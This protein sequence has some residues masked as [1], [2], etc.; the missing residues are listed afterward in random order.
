MI[1]L[2]DSFESITWDTN[3]YWLQVSLDI[4]GGS[5]YTL[6]GAS[7]LL[8]VPYALNAKTDND[9]TVSGTNM[10]SNVTGNIGIGVSIP[11]TSKLD[12]EQQQDFVGQNVH[13][14]EFVLAEVL[15]GNQKNKQTFHRPEFVLAEVLN[16]NKKWA[17]MFIGQSWS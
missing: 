16:G 15:N 6:M 5:S 13:R 3:S 12:I 7:Q 1:P 14:P 8:S 4:A 2:S 10:T 9:W 11:P 17:D